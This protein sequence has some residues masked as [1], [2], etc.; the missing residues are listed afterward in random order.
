[1]IFFLSEYSKFFSLN[2]MM[3]I[4]LIRKI[5]FKLHDKERDLWHA[6]DSL[7]KTITVKSTLVLLL[8]V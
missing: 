4:L 1:M 8:Y 6:P 5:N 7:D 2:Q 3:C